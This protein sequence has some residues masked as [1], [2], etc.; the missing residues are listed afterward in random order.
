MDN[1]S[2]AL[3]LLIV[4]IVSAFL[5]IVLKLAQFVNHFSR[6]KQYLLTEMHRA[7]D[8]NEYRYWRRE[9]RCLY[10]CLI[11]FVTERNVMKVYPVFFHRAKH[12][13][14]EKH[15]D[16]L[17]HILAPSMLAICIC[18]ICLCG[19]SWAWFTASTSTG[20]AQIQSS[21]YKLSYQIGSDTAELAETGNTYTLTSDTTV[22][23]L[24]AIGTAGATGYCSIKIG[25]ETYY[26]KQISV[27]DTSGF[28]FTVNAAKGTKIILTPK[29]GS[30]SGNADLNSGETIGI[31]AVNTQ[32]ETS[33]MAAASTTEPTTTTTS[34]T[35]SSTPAESATTAPEPSETAP[36][37]PESTDTEP[38]SAPETATPENTTAAQTE[39]PTTEES[40]N[41]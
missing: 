23:T 37:Q 26:T 34:A 30:Y 7:A 15:S 33:P 35:P 22:I 3:I 31:T 27:N 4:L 29:W 25:D 28:T 11:P 38:S 2:G 19:A 21:S 16:G 36:T 18:A 8:Y 10:L 40:E 41:N 5:L 9:L 24:K 1:D 14:K 17:M 13:T 32:Q 20:T 6:E 39:P 12:A